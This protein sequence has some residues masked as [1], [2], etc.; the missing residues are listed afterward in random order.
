M[1][2]FAKVNENN[3]VEQ[4]VVVNNSDAPGPYPQSEARGQK[5]LHSLGLKGRWL[6]TSFNNRFR[7]YFAGV[8][9]TY[10]PVEDIFIPPQPYSSWT[11]NTQILK[12]VPPVPYPTDPDIAWS[13][14]EQNQIWK[15]IDDTINGGNA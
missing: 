14:D 5:H 9:Y 3:V 4:V 7:Q 8:G 12:W 11:W 13:W 6:Q 1:A 2:H 10:D 15:K